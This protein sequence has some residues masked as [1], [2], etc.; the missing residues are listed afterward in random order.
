[1]NDIIPSNSAPI[2]RHAVESDFVKSIGTIRANFASREFMYIVDW[3]RL[4]THM[5]QIFIDFA[6]AM[7][8]IMVLYMSNTGNNIEP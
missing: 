8:R 6:F 4:H 1:M 3:R 5:S 7:R 2:R